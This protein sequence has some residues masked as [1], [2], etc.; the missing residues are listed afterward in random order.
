MKLHAAVLF[1]ACFLPL[2]ARG[3]EDSFPSGTSAACEDGAAVSEGPWGVIQSFYVYIEAPDF[4]LEQFELPSGITKWTFRDMTRADVSVLFDEPEIPEAVRDELRDQSRWIV[5][6]DE[7]QVV[8]TAA[9]L[10]ALPP[11]IRARIYA[12]LEQWDVNEF[13]HAPYFV[14]CGDVRRWLGGTGLRSE[15]VDAVAETAYPAGSA[16]CFSDLPLLISMSQSHGEARAILKA[17]SRTRTAILRLR[18]DDESDVRTIRDYWSSGTANAKDFLPLL[19]SVASNREVRHMDI[20]HV[21]PPYPRKLCY[22]YP[23][24]SLA[25]GGRYPDCHWTC[26][27]FFN[28]RPEDRLLDTEG[29]AMF[30]RENYDP[31]TGP[32]QFG[33]ILFFTDA[34][35]NAIHSCVYLAADFVFTKNGANVVNPWLIMDLAEVVDRYS[36]HGEPGIKIY[37]RRP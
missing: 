16:V 27:N 5:T 36:V 31:G 22:T 24:P 26:L 30:V 4:I 18:L 10:M 3:G 19:E 37:R 20:V 9:A 8:P 11:R 23:H 29:A 17:L 13:Q 7:I 32:Y 14:P 34:Q 35:G 28:Y 15:L 33:D 6:D 25:I 1:W 12:V 2:A 21:L